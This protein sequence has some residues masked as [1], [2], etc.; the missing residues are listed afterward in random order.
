MNKCPYCSSENLIKNGKRKEKQRWLCQ[1]C[2]RTHT[3]NAEIAAYKKDAFSY[4]Y[5]LISKL[6]NRPRKENSHFD[7]AKRKIQASNPDIQVIFNNPDAI[8]YINDNSYII[9]PQ[10]DTLSFIQ[11]QYYKKH[12]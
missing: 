5:N 2:K 7:T 4:I 10:N 11:M 1:N 6:Q 8:Q 12:I 3:E 9:V